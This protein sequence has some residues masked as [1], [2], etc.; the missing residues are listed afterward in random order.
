MRSKTMG[1][2]FAVM[3]ATFAV[4]S[5]V[6]SQAFPTKPIRMVIPFPPG[7]VDITGRLLAN[8]MSELLGQPVVVDNRGGA[9]GLIGS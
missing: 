7:G 6:F 4:S 9:N 2:A 8:K 5:P 3:A 1:C